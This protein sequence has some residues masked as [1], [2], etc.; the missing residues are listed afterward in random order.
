M[1][2]DYCHELPVPLD[3]SSLPILIEETGAVHDQPPVAAFPAWSTFPVFAAANHLV[4]DP[5]SGD[6]WVASRGG[7]FQWRSDGSRFS[8]YGP[9]HGLGGNGVGK[10][11]IDDAN[12]VWAA[13][14]EGGLRYLDPPL[15]Q[16]Y[17]LPGTGKFSCLLREKQG[18]IWAAGEAGFFLIGSPD[19]EPERTHAPPDAPPRTLAL[20]G[21]DL[22]FCDAVGLHCLRGE[23][24][25]LLW[26]QP[27]L[28][29][30][31]YSGDT[32]WIGSAAGLFRIMP[33]DGRPQREPSC[34][35]AV[36]ALAQ[37]E[38]GILA[39]CG[40]R[41]GL[42][43]REGYTRFG[44]RHVA[45]PITAVVSSGPRSA[46][47]TS[48][49]G[50]FRLDRKSTIPFVTGESPDR[51]PPT[52]AGSIAAL[53]MQPLATGDRLWIG[54]ALGLF[55]LDVHTRTWTQPDRDAPGAIRHIAVDPGSDR[56]W[57]TTESGA[58][59]Q[60]R[61]GV[62]YKRE[63]LETGPI[64]QLAFGPDGVLYAAATNGVYKREQNRMSL[65]PTSL[66]LPPSCLSLTVLPEQDHLLLGT[67]TGLFVP[68]PGGNGPIRASGVLGHCAV[69]QLASLSHGLSR[70]YLVGTGNGLYAGEGNRFAD[71]QPIEPVGGRWIGA[72]LTDQRETGATVWVG[73][74]SG[75]YHLEQTA[76]GFAGNAHY[77]S[78]NSGLPA[79]RVTALA[80]ERTETKTV[81][82]IGTVRGLCRF[83]PQ[84]KKEQGA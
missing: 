42:S 52:L 68:S 28:T 10:L 70:H 7:V 40:D 39:A 66:E 35:Q 65:V 31:L 56:V 55:F 75:L 80:L 50:L 41:V 20:V 71:Y 57:A 69:H 4:R 37:G 24:A 61:G 12:R 15:W 16:A 62:L 82:W 54:T 30:L 48:H 34:P 6:L 84:T 29:A 58:L 44:A 14:E 27:G 47:V 59:Y 83:D 76:A 21:D 64:H 26:R 18:R 49:R 5:R 81:L 9:E 11:A 74:D 45:G 60:L 23:D 17:R 78:A 77:T 13:P 53:A 63:R 73:T 36:T 46:W 32:L 67:S 8:R 72:L 3:E 19:H 2:H 79:N 51:P 22:Y 43:S 1:G 25:Q 38:N 33:P